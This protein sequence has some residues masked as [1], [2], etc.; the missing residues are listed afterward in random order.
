MAVGLRQRVC[1]RPDCVRSRQ[2]SLRPPNGP[3]WIQNACWPALMKRRWLCGGALAGQVMAARVW[4][5]RRGYTGEWPA[6]GTWR[7][8]ERGSPPI[9]RRGARAELQGPVW[10]AFGTRV[11]CSI[12]G[13]LSRSVGAKGAQVAGA[14]SERNWSRVARGR[15]SLLISAPVIRRTINIQGL[16]V[17]LAR[18]RA[19]STERQ[20]VNGEHWTESSEH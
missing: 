18:R 1:G 5:G 16:P 13:R 20:T 3:L 19:V 11:G 9:C 6:G 7:R 10:G 2:D 17:T 8:A 4:P 12:C 15:R 14:Q